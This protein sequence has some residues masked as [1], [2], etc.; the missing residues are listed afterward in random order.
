MWKSCRF[1]HPCVDNL[2]NSMSHQPW[3]DRYATRIAR[4]ETARFAQHPPRPFQTDFLRQRRRAGLRTG[5]EVE[6]GAD[7]EQSGSVELIKTARR[8]QFL[9]RSAERDEAELRTGGADA[10]D[11]EVGLAGIRIEI[12]G[13]SMVTRDFQPPKS[14]GQAFC[15]D[16]ERVMIGTQHEDGQSLSLRLLAD[17]LHKIGAGCAPDPRSQETTQHDNGKAVRCYKTSSTIG[18][19]KIR[20]L[21]QLHDMVEI[22]RADAEVIALLCCRYDR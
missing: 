14:L 17:G 16:R 2:W 5:D 11:R 18:R 15:R 1:P 9:A 4:P 7:A 6:R 8:K 19:A 3:N 20:P 13:W 10:V 12:R 22:E 21:L